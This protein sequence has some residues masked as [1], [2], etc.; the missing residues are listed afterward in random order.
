MEILYKE[1]D[2]WMKENRPYLNFELTD[3]PSCNGYRINI[4]DPG[5][6]YYSHVIKDFDDFLNLMNPALN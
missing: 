1:I 2:N 3:C 4:I 5:D 6:I